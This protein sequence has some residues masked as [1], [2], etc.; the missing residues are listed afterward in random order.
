MSKDSFQLNRMHKVVYKLGTRIRTVE[1]KFTGISPGGTLAVFSPRN[2]EEKT[3]GIPLT[4]IK[5]AELVVF[6]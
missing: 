5:T 6:A 4:N 1:M 3:L 2:P